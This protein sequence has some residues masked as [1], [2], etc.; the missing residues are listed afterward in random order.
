M[1]SETQTS[2]WIEVDD[3]D[4]N[5]TWPTDQSDSTPT[6][7]AMVFSYEVEALTS[8]DSGEPPSPFILT[9]LD[10]VEAETPP[11]D[12]PITFGPMLIVGNVDLHKA[13]VSI[14]INAAGNLTWRC[15]TC[16][17]ECPF[18][19]LQTILDHLRDRHNEENT[20]KDMNVTCGGCD[21][22]LPL[23]RLDVHQAIK[24][25]DFF[26]RTGLPKPSAIASHLEEQE[27]KKAQW[28]KIG[29]ILRHRKRTSRSKQPSR[30]ATYK[31]SYLVQW[32][33][34]EQAWLQEEEISTSALEDYWR[35]EDRRSS[36]EG[37]P[38]KRL[39]LD[40]DCPI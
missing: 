5:C 36:K 39:R 4:L 30:Q 10:N 26:A 32:L 20:V 29:T 6:S 24:H 34:Q 31:T 18:E 25:P 22:I 15:Y 23:R 17:Q 27:L 13:A 1:N 2:D 19:A 33:N 12:P 37:P 35:Q 40:R 14:I 9:M 16:D 8:I 7:D 21:A 3:L 11:S 38:R 28:F